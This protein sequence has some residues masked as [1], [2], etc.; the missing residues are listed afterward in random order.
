MPQYIQ[1]HEEGGVGIIDAEV[2]GAN[3]P[4][5]PRQI[6]FNSPVDKTGMRV[7]L[8]ER[9]LEAAPQEPQIER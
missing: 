8:Q 1:Y 6:V 2:I 9:A 5:H 4:I 3:P 7:N